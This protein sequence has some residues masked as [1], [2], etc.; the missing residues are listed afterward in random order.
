[1]AI[2]LENEKFEGNLGK[3]FAIKDLRP[4]KHIIGINIPCDGMNRK[5][6]L[7]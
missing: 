4:T 3:S 5:L 7:S 2:I 1:L 6:W